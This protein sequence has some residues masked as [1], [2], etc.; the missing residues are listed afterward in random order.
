M[1]SGLQHSAK[2][3]PSSI[4]GSSSTITFVRISLW[5][6]DRP[7]PPCTGQLD[8]RLGRRDFPPEPISAS[9]GN[10]SVSS[11]LACHMLFYP[12]RCRQVTVEILTC[13]LKIDPRLALTLILKLIFVR[14]GA[15]CCKLLRDP[16]SGPERIQ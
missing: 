12:I 5:G 15:F 11:S 6:C 13:N 8:C 2:P 7:Y 10:I 4:N 1:P 14:L 16:I 3:K 9:K